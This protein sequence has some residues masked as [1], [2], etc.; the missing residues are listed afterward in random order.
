[1]H[2][3]KPDNY[4]LGITNEEVNQACI[5]KFITVLFILCVIALWV[6]AVVPA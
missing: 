1:M 3:H 6:G 2:D 5:A 4:D